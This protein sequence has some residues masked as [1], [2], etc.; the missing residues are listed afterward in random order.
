[1][2]PGFHSLAI[3]DL[4]RLER[5]MSWQPVKGLTWRQPGLDQRRIL[6]WNPDS[7]RPLAR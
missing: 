7:S 4:A 2:M 5:A 6:Q 3:V 1:M